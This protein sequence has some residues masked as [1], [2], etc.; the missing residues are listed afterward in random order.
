MSPEPKIDATDRAILAELQ[1][2]ARRS[3]KALAAA[4]GLAPSTTL[5][6]VRDLEARGAILGYHAEVDPEVLG[7]SIGALV[8]VRLSPKDGDL[9]SR[10]VDSLW[11]LDEVLAVTLL[12]GPYDL[13]VQLSVP[14]IAELRGLVLDK[15]ASFDGVSDEQTMI[16]FEHRRKAVLRPLPGG[17]PDRSAGADGGR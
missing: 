13:I 12:T 6:R 10:F 17:A 5:G 2:D 4:V 16:I 1:S 8:S 9:V 7:H 3:N 14:S 15:I 11:A